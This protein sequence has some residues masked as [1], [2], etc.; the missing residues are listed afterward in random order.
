MSYERKIG[1]FRKLKT[2]THVELIQKGM[3]AVLF[4]RTE[5]RGWSDLAPTSDGLVLVR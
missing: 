2:D 4:P 3:R 1:V 5:V